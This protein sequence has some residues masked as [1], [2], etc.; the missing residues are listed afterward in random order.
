VVLTLSH[1]VSP[2]SGPTPAE[3]PARERGARAGL[4]G[5]TNETDD[6]SPSACPTVAPSHHDQFIAAQQG[7][8]T[9]VARLVRP[10]LYEIGLVTLDRTKR[11][12]RFPAAVNQ[13][14]GRVEYALVTTQGKVHESVFRTEA[15]PQHI[16]LAMLL[17]GVKAASTNQLPEHP[18]SALPGERVGI[19]VCWKRGRKE[20]RR[21]LADFVRL[22]APGRGEAWREWVY[23][24]SF[25][26]D[27][28]LA[29]QRGGS[30]IALITDPTALVNNPGTSRAD[31]EIHQVKSKALPPEDTPVELVFKVAP[32]VP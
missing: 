30:I 28:A 10:G 6:L 27:G 19:E 8:E 25:V 20:I 15:D 12:V 32:G 24:G 14:A 5:G 17:L 3:D 2:L 18:T 31:D 21:P 22:S 23:N 1:P 16:H 29:A 13:R 26:V 9:E 11:L 4:L 7:R